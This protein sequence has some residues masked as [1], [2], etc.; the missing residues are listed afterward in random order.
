MRNEGSIHEGVNPALRGK[1]WE[2]LKIA[3]VGTKLFHV[4]SFCQLF[5][6]A[7]TGMANEKDK[8]PDV[9]QV[10]EV[11]RCLVFVFLL[12]DF[13]LLLLPGHDVNNKS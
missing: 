7:Y 1:A 13:F 3:R 9:Q 5:V 2:V 10:F 11:L 6:S 4:F 12:F 8:V